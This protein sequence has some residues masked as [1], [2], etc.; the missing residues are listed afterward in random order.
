MPSRKH[1]K[2]NLHPPRLDELADTDVDPDLTGGEFDGDG[3]D[4]GDRD[5]EGV[6]AA[7][8]T[9]ELGDD[10]DLDGVDVRAISLGERPVLHDVRFARCRVS[11]VS[12]ADS[13]F[14]G[15]ELRDVRCLA[16]DAAGARWPEVSMTRV[17]FHDCRLSGIDL[18][19]ATL[20]HVRFAGC[21]LDAA[22]LRMIDADHVR[23][24]DCDLRDTDFG[25]AKLRSVAFAGSRLEA[26]EFS[27]AHC[28]SVDLRGALVLSI[29]GVAGLRGATIGADQVV[30]LAPAVFADLGI[31]IAD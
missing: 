28:E 10:A 30:P 5:G 27:G 14:L 17:E 13:H 19:Q 6:V 29:R 4:D 26:V 23:F 3:A 24:D 2:V 8:A 22:N 1:A 21:R 9:V 11:G 15:L 12:L 18:A 20:R 7:A 25:A 31:T 16:T